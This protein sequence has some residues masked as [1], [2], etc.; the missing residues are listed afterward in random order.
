MDVAMT[1]VV[2][3]MDF[4][5]LAGTDDMIL[6]LLAAGGPRPCTLEGGDGG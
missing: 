2:V 4:F 6:S 5:V 1:S 3:V